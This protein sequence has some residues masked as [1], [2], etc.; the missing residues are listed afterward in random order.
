MP[1]PALIAT[2]IATTAYGAYSASQAASEQAKATGEQTATALRLAEETKTEQAR[3][4]AESKANQ[5]KLLAAPGIAAEE[6]RKEAMRRRKSQTQTLLTGPLGDVGAADS[7]K[8]TLLG[9]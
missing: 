5:E 2:M 3:L 7:L 4:E 8:K 1:I 9:E 6:A